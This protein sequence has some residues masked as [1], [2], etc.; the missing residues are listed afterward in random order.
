MLVTAFEAVTSIAEHQGAGHE[1]CPPVGGPVLKTAPRDG[2]HAYQ[3]VLLFK[4]P[5]V[6]AGRADN[7]LNAPT[8][9]GRHQMH[10]QGHGFTLAIF[11]KRRLRPR[12]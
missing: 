7:I 3:I 8:W 11:P 2:G 4:R 10:A 1:G 9:A 5:V 6:G 12:H